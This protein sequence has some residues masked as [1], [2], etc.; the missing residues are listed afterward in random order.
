VVII[1]GGLSGLA[2]GVALADAGMEV[3]LLERRGHL[4][5]RAYSFLDPSTGCVVDNGQ[6]LFMG[7]YRE[8]ISFL[9]KIGCR[10]RL[11][12]QDRLRVDF[13]DRDGPVAF[14]CPSLPAPLHLLAGLA[15]MRG[16]RLS[17]KLRALGLGRAIRASNDDLADHLTV[18]EWLASL[19]Q[20]ER[21]NQRFLHPLSIATLNDSPDI[22]SAR[23]L[24]VVLRQA[25]G[26]SRSDSCIG[27]SRV[28][29]SDLYTDA[30]RRHIES[31]GGEVRI[32][33]SVQ[34]LAIENRRAVW[35]E[36]KNG[37]RVEGDYFISA[38]PHRA[39]LDM[40][41][42]DMRC[43]EFSSL[44]RLDLSPIVSIN[45]WFDLPVFDRQFAGVLGARIQWLFNKDLI[46]KGGA[47][48]NHL[49]V[50][51]SA[52][53]KFVDCAKSE[54]VAMALEDLRELIPSARDA[55]V[56]H[57]LIVKE[58]EATLS[59]TVESDSLRPKARTSIANLLLAGDWTDTGLPATIESAVLSG[60][61]AAREI[62]RS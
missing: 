8:T 49:A 50:I 14:R 22:A 24:S 11:E 36:L 45:L 42:E 15:R 4:G 30:A 60:H 58:R 10:D 33:S 17:D 38:T 26:G 51:I 47:T 48:A 21:M 54:L 46:V 35:A 39:F 56:I 18:D 34:R 37:E 9:G 1:G 16:L 19:H 13:I 29:L 55:R 20:S 43:G 5:G 3:R 57:S 52:A 2:A 12:F 40:L 28:G 44:S 23:M 41:P 31:R 27:I 6:H 32:G 53:R 25:F 62:T 59:H 61:T 7:C